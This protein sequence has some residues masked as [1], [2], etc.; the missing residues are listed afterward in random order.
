VNATK[1]RVRRDRLE[2]ADGSSWERSRRP[3]VVHPP[4]FVAMT[5]RDKQQCSTPSSLC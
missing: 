4:T 5:E 1:D 2:D 3:L